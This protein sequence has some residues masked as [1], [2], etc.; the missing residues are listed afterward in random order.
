MISIEKV[1]LWVTFLFIYNLEYLE[2]HTYQYVERPNSLNDP[3][4]LD[5]RL[6][7]IV[8]HR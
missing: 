1:T 8:V 5:N 2:I 6:N 3:Y 7:D 4:A